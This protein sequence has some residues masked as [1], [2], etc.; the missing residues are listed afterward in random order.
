MSKQYLGLP[1]PTEHQIKTYKRR[2]F[3]NRGTCIKIGK[4]DKCGE[5]PYY[6][7]DGD[8]GKHTVRIAPWKVESE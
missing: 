8:W 5:A 1:R 4:K 3:R 7:L 2:I 6:F